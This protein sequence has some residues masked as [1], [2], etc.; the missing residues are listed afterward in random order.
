MSVAQLR[1]ED[2]ERVDRFWHLRQSTLFS[3]LS[4]ADL[5][6]VA[7]VLTDRIFPKGARI[8]NR[9]EPAEFLY[10]LNRGSV[11]ISLGNNGGKEKLVRF[12][13]IGD[14]FGEALLSGEP[15]YYAEASAHEECW[16]SA[17]S[18]GQLLRLARERP[19]VS[20]NLFGMLSRQLLDAMNEIEDLS[21]LN[22]EQRL[23]KRLLQLAATH[24]KP[25]LSHQRMT[26]LK[27]S[28]SHEDL[29][30]L[31]GANRPHVS[32]IMS[33]FK[34]QGWIHYSGRRLLIEEDRL[35]EVCASGKRTGCAGT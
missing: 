26:K 6:A 16:V 23:A 3:N 15:R 8:F 30:R 22:T 24:G 17:I 9:D 12:L 10:I 19:S 11:R 34:K 5:S 21:F 1:C 33:H 28:V 32:T 20:A 35:R 25:V 4:Y 2:L 14:V 27:I 13:T 18:K 29:A 7:Q 31:I